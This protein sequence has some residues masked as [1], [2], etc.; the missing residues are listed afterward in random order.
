MQPARNG[1]SM[2]RMMPTGRNDAGKKSS[3]RPMP[4]P[5]QAWSEQAGR[6]TKS[7]GSGGIMP[8]A[9]VECQPEGRTE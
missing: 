4:T 7:G 2:R 3:A 1:G 5:A 6:K 8:T 9:V